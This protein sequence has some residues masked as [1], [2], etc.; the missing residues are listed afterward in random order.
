MKK[1][2]AIL[3]VVIVLVTGV[4]LVMAGPVLCADCDT[5]A[6]ASTCALGVLL[7]AGFALALL[8]TRLRRDGVAVERLLFAFALERPPRL[9]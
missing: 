4:P 2:L 5:A 8:M 1:G 7:T 6:M 3:L 9:A